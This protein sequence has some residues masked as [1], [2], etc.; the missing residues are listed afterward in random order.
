MQLIIETYSFDFKPEGL[1]LM[2]AL[3]TQKVEGQR[4]E[5]TSGMKSS[6]KG[7]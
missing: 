7:H 5:V 4:S 1:S 6:S 3:W 2:H